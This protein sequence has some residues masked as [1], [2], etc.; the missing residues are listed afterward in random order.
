MHAE[1]LQSLIKRLLASPPFTKQ[2]QI[3]KK[4]IVYIYIAKRLRLEQHKRKL[5]LSK[6]RQIICSEQPVSQLQFVV[7]SINKDC[8]LLSSNKRAYSFLLRL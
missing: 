8:G 5:V 6:I 4:Y 1:R 2:R 3:S 7:P